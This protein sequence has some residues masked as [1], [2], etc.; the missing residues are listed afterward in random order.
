[1]AESLQT[2]QDALK[3][4]SKDIQHPVSGDTSGGVTA[5]GGTG[6]ANGFSQPNILVSTPK[7]IALV[8][9]NSTHIVAEKE[10]NVV[11]N[12]NTYMATGKSL[13]VA[14]AEKVSFFA[15]KLGAF[16]VTA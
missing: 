15:Q 7:D 3:A 1:Q 2:G 8:A 6:S 16:F 11:S 4:L 10:I 5:G 14:A 13:V 12:E 9:D